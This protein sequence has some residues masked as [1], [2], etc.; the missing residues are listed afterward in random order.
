MAAPS[1]LSLLPGRL[2]NE[3]T[4]GGSTS[5]TQGPS[6]LGWPLPSQPAF[7]QPL[8]L[9]RPERWRPRSG[10]GRW[11][12]TQHSGGSHTPRGGLCPPSAASSAAAP[13]L[14]ILHPHPRP[15][16]PQSAHPE[17]SWGVAGKGPR[18]SPEAGW[19]GPAPR[20]GAPPGPAPSG[21]ELL[22]AVQRRG[23]KP[24]RPGS[25]RP[26]FPTPPPPAVRAAS[27]AAPAGFGAAARGRDASLQ[28]GAHVRRWESD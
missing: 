15:W 13:D 17:T 11:A 26:A 12:D 28:F 22:G 14:R 24:I 23:V 5:G 10:R 20:A 3:R 6:G 18:T 1:A 21:W 25:L 16:A 19:R 2:N 9:P 7:S 27:C 4:W 8:S